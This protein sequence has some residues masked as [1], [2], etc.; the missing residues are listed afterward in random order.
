MTKQG[1]L[2][3]LGIVVLSLATS[4]VLIAIAFFFNRKV[5]STEPTEQALT[6]KKDSQ[7]ETGNRNRNT[8]TLEPSSSKDDP[9]GLVSGRVVLATKKMGEEPLREALVYLASC[10]HLDRDI[11]TD[12]I[13]A[14]VKD[15]HLSPEPL[16]VV[17]GQKLVVD[18]KD[19]D[20]YLL[21]YHSPYEPQFDRGIPPDLTRQEQIFRKPFL[22]V[23][24][25]CSINPTFNAQMSVVPNKFFTVTGKNGSFKLPHDLPPGKYEL[26]AFYRGHPEAKQKIEVTSGQQTEVKLI[27]PPKDD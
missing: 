12:P 3:A 6:T 13:T 8:C 2:L 9:P 11:P 17:A 25:T 23:D 22:S 10:E 15:G 21:H 26:C 24:V 4:A 18:I 14:V 16:I 27:I 20:T 7:D 5:G 19:D 1:F